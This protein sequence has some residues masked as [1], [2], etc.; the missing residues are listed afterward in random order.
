MNAMSGPTF[1]QVA[2][3]LVLVVIAIIV[4]RYWKLGLTKDMSVGTVRSFIQLVA[5][6]YALEF[7]FDLDTWWMITATILIMMTIGA[8]TSVDRVKN[9]GRAFPIAWFAMGAGSLITIAVMV[10]VDII[11]FN[12]RYV[13]PLG[14]MIIS[15]AMNASAL[16]MT[17]LTSDIRNNALA[18]ETSLALGKS[19]REA[20]RGFQREA[21]TAG[22][23]S[24]LN[25][26]K[27]VGIVALPGAMTGMILGGAEP[28][29]AVL[30]QII[31]AYMLLSAVTITS[32]VAVE[33]T[34]RR[35][36]TSHHQLKRIGS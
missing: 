3:A 7:I 6:G 18:I 2:L 25:F 22:M 5:V 14:G 32:I 26:M 21:A 27:T 23:L 16:A 33:L 20:S 12:S 30:L 11:P 9:I 35:F 13:I 19:W 31:V 10:A 1:V 4:S 29:E 34:I 17:R 36:F 24:I 15:N 8:Y 28:L